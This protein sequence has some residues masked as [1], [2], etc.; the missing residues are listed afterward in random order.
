M[1]VIR[2]ICLAA[3]VVALAGL[4]WSSLTAA[5]QGP[6]PGPPQKVV[7]PDSAKNPSAE[8]LAEG[9]LLF[10]GECGECHGVDASGNVGPDLHG[11]TQKRG[12]E[13]VFSVIRN[14]IPGTGMAPV[15]NLNDKRA[16]EVVAYLHTLAP[17]AADE[18]VKGDPAK[19]A[20]LY[21]SSGCATCHSINAKGGVFAPQ[22]TRIGAERSPK[23]LRDF[24]LDPG[25][26]PPA[27]PALPERGAFTGYLVTHVVTKGGKEI[28]GIRI[29]ED[30]FTLD[31]EDL[32]G[33]YYSF[34]KSDLK[35]V[36]TEPGKSF[37]PS[38]SNLSASDLD[39]L[40][41][42]LASLKGAE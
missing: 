16:W 37:M 23:Y 18:E 34:N 30:T 9:K 1:L 4:G 13:G 33:H 25:A 3:L 20:Q 40:V 24:L 14:G 42:Y 6:P 32:S 17:T 15:S 41:A 31:L 12:D 7:E 5:P 8:E 29:N 27:D 36:T 35:T 38:F 10:Q 2:R 11:V 28:T 22:L 21:Q 19:G 26:H 39:D